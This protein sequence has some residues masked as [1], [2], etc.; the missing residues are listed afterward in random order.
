MI[1]PTKSTRYARHSQHSQQQQQQQQQQPRMRWNRKRSLQTN[2]RLNSDSNFLTTKTTVVCLRTIPL[3]I[4]LLYSLIRVS[5]SIR[6][7]SSTQHDRV[8]GDYNHSPSTWT[9]WMMDISSMSSKS[10]LS[11]FLRST[12]KNDQPYDDRPLPAPVPSTIFFHIQVFSDGEVDRFSSSRRMIQQQMQQILQRR[13]SFHSIRYNIASTNGAEQF[14][15]VSDMNDL[16]TRACP[17]CIRLVSNTSIA[18][19]SSQ[20]QHTLQYLWEYCHSHPSEYVTYLHTMDPASEGTKFSSSIHDIGTF[21]ALQCPYH[22]SSSLESST[23]CTS[24][25]LPFQTRPSYQHDTNQWTASCQYVNRLVPP[26][27]YM[28]K[29]KQM[30]KTLYQNDDYA[31]LRPHNITFTPGLQKQVLGIDDDGDTKSEAW[32]SRW[33]HSHPSLQPC[34]IITPHVWQEAVTNL[35]QGLPTITLEWNLQLAPADGTKFN[36]KGA[37][38]SWQ[39]LEG[40]LFEWQFI[41]NQSHDGDYGDE[42][43]LQQREEQHPSQLVPSNDSWVYPYYQHAK[44]GIKCYKNYLSNEFL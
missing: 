11:T 30:Y 44:F 36:V 14:I 40:R 37:P 34:D 32:T 7:L 3:L 1:I 8:D 6:R 12:K 16:V 35:S 24:C 26:S 22:L 18:T 20:Q 9:T 19:S 38:T 23:S 15:D 41:N 39:R 13:R 33:I 21:A 25:G 28:V 4:I 5:S 27:Q 43:S 2:S 29:L 17:D 42:T 10:N 31:C